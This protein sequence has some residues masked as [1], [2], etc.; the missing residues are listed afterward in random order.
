M[1][2][3]VNLSFGSF[4]AL[5]NI[6]AWKTY[7]RITGKKSGKALGLL[8][9]QAEGL[10]LVFLSEI[11]YCFIYAGERKHGKS[12]PMNLDEFQEQA[13]LKDVMTVIEACFGS[14]ETEKKSQEPVM[15]PS[16]LK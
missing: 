4:Y 1:D 10:D 11:A 13:G 6:A 2:I 7:E 15:Q 14:E 5:E 16:V 3:Q 8:Q 9:N 12:F